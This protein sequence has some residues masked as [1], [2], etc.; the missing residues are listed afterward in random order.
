M[1]HPGKL[2]ARTGGLGPVEHRG[3]FRAAKIHVGLDLYRVRGWTIWYR[4]TTLVLLAPAVLATC[5][6]V[7]EPTPPDPTRHGRHTRPIALTMAET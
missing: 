2:G 5:A 4:H 3:L 7:T 6:A 1:S